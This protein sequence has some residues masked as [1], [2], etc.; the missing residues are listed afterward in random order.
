VLLLIIALLFNIN[1]VPTFAQESGSAEM[2]APEEESIPAPRTPTTDEEIEAHFAALGA[3]AEACIGDCTSARTSAREHAN[4]W[5]RGSPCGRRQLHGSQFCPNTASVVLNPYA[6]LADREHIT[7]ET[8]RNYLLY[9]A[10]QQ[11]SNAVTHFDF[12][13]ADKATMNTGGNMFL[14]TSNCRTQLVH[15]SDLETILEA[16]NHIGTTVEFTAEESRNFCR[17]AS[18]PCLLAGGRMRTV[19]GAQRCVANGVLLDTTCLSLPTAKLL[20]LKNALQA[21]RGTGSSCLRNRVGATELAR[22]FSQ[23]FSDSA[24]TTQVC[25]E[26]NCSATAPFFTTEGGGRRTPGT[27]ARA[28]TRSAN[29]A[30]GTLYALNLDRPQADLNGTFFHEMLH[31]AGQC[32]HAL[33]NFNNADLIDEERRPPFCTSD[34]VAASPPD[35]YSQITGSNSAMTYSAYRDFVQMG[36][37][38]ELKTELLAIEDNQSVCVRRNPCN[39]SAPMPALF[40]GGRHLIDPAYACEDFCFGPASRPQP[41]RNHE[42]NVCLQSQATSRSSAPNASNFCPGTGR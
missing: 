14:L 10:Q 17:L 42:R 36:F 5:D 37:L 2:R 4:I 38:N 30:N 34:Y 13:D 23:T 27:Y 29:A 20:K 40:V 18:N 9:Q 35:M 39:S 26:G 31:R 25:C 16:H 1:G 3:V 12:N 41:I 7:S 11:V 6:I 28:T 24:P 22:D 15:G 21:A 32:Q 19:A 33:H 8:C